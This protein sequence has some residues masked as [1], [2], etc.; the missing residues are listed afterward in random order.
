[1]DACF[2]P[3]SGLVYDTEPPG[4]TG[5]GDNGDD[6]DNGGDGDGE[7]LAGFGGWATVLGLIGIGAGVLT[8][9]NTET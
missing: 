9:V 7:L 8:Y 3:E 6:G 2:D 4:G 1:M 5:P